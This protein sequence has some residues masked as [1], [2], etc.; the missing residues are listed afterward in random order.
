MQQLYDWD[1]PTAVDRQ[2]LRAPVS[3]S[4]KT[5]LLANPENARLVSSQ[6][7]E[8]TTFTIDPTPFR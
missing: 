6:A 7:E 3:V 8:S 1:G 2:G 4:E 5:S